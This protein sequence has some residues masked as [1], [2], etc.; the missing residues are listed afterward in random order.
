M[1]NIL[2]LTHDLNP[3][4]GWGRYSSDLI[5]GIESIGFKTQ[6]LVESKSDNYKGTLLLYR[7]LKIF[8][9]FSK[10]RQAIKNCD[11]IHSLDVYPYSII[12]DQANL[13]ITKKHVITGVGT[14]AVAPLFNKKTSYLA[15][16]AVMRSDRV[17][18][19]S[20]YTKMQMQKVLKKDITV[21]NPG[22][23][24]D[25][26]YISRQLLKSNFILSV[27]ALKE[28]KGQHISISAFALARKKY[29]DLKYILVG[30]QKDK[31]YFSYLKKII[32]QEKID[33][34]VEFKTGIEDK[35]LID[36][37]SQA[38]LFVMTSVNKGFHFEGYGLVFLE[39]SAAGLPVIGTRGNGIEDTVKDGVNGILVKQNDV[40]GTAQAITKVLANVDDYSKNSYIWAK[41]NDKQK[42]AKQYADIY[43][44]L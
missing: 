5:K 43:N 10:I 8:K 31:G 37:Y 26:F 13:F 34:Y 42:A 2:Y 23:D 16:R 19:I 28:R 44:S 27:G 38:K 22:I 7:G 4:S 3:K 25:K 21:V 24:F 12:A 11:I 9:N 15:R 1:K 20:N 14:Y 33:D 6:A 17:C 32:S 18:T 40:E 30:S 29:P 35:E 36:L 39:A 41:D